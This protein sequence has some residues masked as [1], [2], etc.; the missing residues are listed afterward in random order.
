LN[1]ENLT[2]CPESGGRTMAL[3]KVRIKMRYVQEKGIKLCL[4]TPEA[5][6]AV[7]SS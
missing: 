6:T 5:A 2:S 1:L 7:R 3:A 4:N